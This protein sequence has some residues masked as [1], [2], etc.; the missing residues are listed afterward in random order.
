MWPPAPGQSTE[1]LGAALRRAST[2]QLASVLGAGSSNEVNSI[3][4]G[5]QPNALGSTTG[6]YVYTAVTPCR[7][8]DTR[9]AGGGGPIAA[10][11]TRDFYV[12]GTVDISGQGGNASG[13]ASPRGEPRAVHINLTAIPVAFPGNLRVYPQ[14][15]ATPL[16]STVNFQ[17]NN[18]A[19]ALVVQTFFS[20]GPKE[21]Q[22]FASNTAD[23]VADVL[24]Y[25]YDADLTL[26]SGK[27]MTGAYGAHAT[28]ATVGEFFMASFS[29]P[30]RLASAP[31]AP[32]ANFIPS[33]GAP[34]ANCPGSAANPTALAGNLCVYE[35]TAVNRT[36]A[37]LFGTS[38]GSCASLP[39]FG[40]GIAFSATAAGRSLSYGS[41]AV[42][43]P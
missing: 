23:V 43:A 20:F 40:A 39:T 12:Y 6:D 28:N 10:G 41:W 42:T 7:I 17:A 16:V 21:I 11:G 9:N 19:N 15:V 5:P 27:T 35:L 38:S 31:S 22:V 8:F 37:C 26:G 14:N 30:N 2:E 36:Y 4:R 1:Q 33:G 34:T 13:C 25:F 29:F 18:I 24:G 32:A 3:L